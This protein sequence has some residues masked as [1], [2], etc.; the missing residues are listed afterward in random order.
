MSFNRFKK[1]SVKIKPLEQIIER[2]NDQ[3]LNAT[4]RVHIY[5]QYNIISL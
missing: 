1:L 2:Q 3:I 5:F 4:C